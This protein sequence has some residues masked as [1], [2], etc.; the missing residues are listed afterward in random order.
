MHDVG[1]RGPTLARHPW[2]G[3]ATR[4]LLRRRS[5]QKAGCLPGHDDE[6]GSELLPSTQPQALATYPALLISCIQSFITT[7]LP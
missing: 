2:P 5:I 1:V 6:A 7:H 4:P 3:L